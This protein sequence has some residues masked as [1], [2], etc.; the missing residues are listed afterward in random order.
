MPYA[1]DIVCLDFFSILELTVRIRTAE[2]VIRTRCRVRS[3]GT[4]RSVVQ[5]S[6]SNSS[7]SSSSLFLLLSAAFPKR[8][9]FLVLVCGLDGHCVK[10]AGSSFRSGRKYF[11]SGWVDRRGAEKH[12]DRY[13]KDD[14]NPYV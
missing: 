7:K 2:V 3:L 4:I 6:N 9:Q 14:A 1:P 13:G 11:A 10:A 12:I 5:K 8:C